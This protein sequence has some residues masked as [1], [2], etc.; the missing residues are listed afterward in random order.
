[1]AMLHLRFFRIFCPFLTTLSSSSPMQSISGK[2]NKWRGGHY[3]ANKGK[4]MTFWPFFFLFLL[5]QFEQVGLKTPLACTTYIASTAHTVYQGGITCG[6]I[7]EPRKSSKAI[8]ERQLFCSIDSF[9]VLSIDFLFY[10]KL[11]CS[12][13]SFSVL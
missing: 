11:F 6:A 10:R 5:F 8:D 9:S 1:M 13:H 7:D 4:Q 2:E 3:C 12:I